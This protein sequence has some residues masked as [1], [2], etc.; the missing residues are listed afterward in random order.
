MDAYHHIQEL[1]VAW[2]EDNASGGLLA[3][4]KDDIHQLG[5][6]FG[7]GDFGGGGDF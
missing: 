3:V 7:G 4:L 2:F 5:G 1:E 6:D